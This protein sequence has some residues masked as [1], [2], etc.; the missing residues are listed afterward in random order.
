MCGGL[1]S[2]VGCGWG[3]VCWILLGCVHQARS[4]GGGGYTLS[5]AAALRITHA[6]RLAVSL[7]LKASHEFDEELISRA[8]HPLE[9]ATREN[10]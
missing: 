4:R 8:M 1:G 5:A 6:A 10:N 2:G 3:G 7:T 9:H